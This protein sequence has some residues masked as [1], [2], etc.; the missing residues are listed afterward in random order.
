MTVEV[1]SKS[2]L[3]S[4]IRFFDDS[5][6]NTKES[7]LLD[8]SWGKIKEFALFDGSWGKVKY[9]DLFDGSWDASKASETQLYYYFVLV[10][11]R[12]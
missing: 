8:D 11:I 9:F 2:S 10:Q 4:M 7:A 6:G 12:G 3:Y 1:N 5:W